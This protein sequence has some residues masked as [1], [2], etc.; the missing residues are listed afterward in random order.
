[1][2]R[3]QILLA[4]DLFRKPATTFR[5]LALKR[6]AQDVAQ[7]VEQ[8]PADIEA[9]RRVGSALAVL[10]RSTMLA[11]TSSEAIAGWASPLTAR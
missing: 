2:D 7:P 4:L 1:M 11:S 5:D 8:C 9:A 10:A 3:T 6:I